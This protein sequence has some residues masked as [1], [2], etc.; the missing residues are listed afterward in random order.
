MRWRGQGKWPRSEK[1]LSSRFL[2]WGVDWLDLHLCGMVNHPPWT[3]DHHLGRWSF[4]TRFQSRFK[5]L[6]WQ[7]VAFLLEAFGVC[8]CFSYIKHDITDPMK[9]DN[10]PQVEQS[11]RRS[12]L[13]VSCAVGKYSL[14]SS[15]ELWGPIFT[16]WVHHADEIYTAKSSKFEIVAKC[17]LRRPIIRDKNVGS[18]LWVSIE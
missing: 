8:C 11:L 17:A 5:V 15:F 6:K 10:A 7:A 4:G 9:I 1:Q 2:C 18:Q 14:I 13:V 12:V 16:L 3:N